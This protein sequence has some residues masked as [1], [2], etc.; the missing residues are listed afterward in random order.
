MLVRTLA[1]ALDLDF[2]RIQFTPDLMPADI[3][4]LNDR[5]GSRRETT[6]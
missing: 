5:R 3:L 1:D 2:N 4:Q 6:I